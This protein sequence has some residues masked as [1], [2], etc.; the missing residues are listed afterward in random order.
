M[1]DAVFKKNAKTAS[2]YEKECTGNY[3][4]TQSNRNESARY[5]KRFIIVNIK[6][7]TLKEQKE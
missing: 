4:K 3:T 6:T 2:A 7:T 5:K 1:N